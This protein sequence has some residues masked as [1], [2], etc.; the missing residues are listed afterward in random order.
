MKL[1]KDVTTAQRAN[2]RDSMLQSAC[3]VMLFRKSQRSS[4]LQKKLALYLLYNRCPKAVFGVLHRC[5]VS[6]SYEGALGALK[7]TSTRALEKLEKWKEEGCR[8]M[9]V[10]DNINFSVTASEDTI[11]AKT[12]KINATIG[13]LIRNRVD[14]PIEQTEENLAPQKKA[15][16]LHSGF[17]F[18]TTEELTLL[19]EVLTTLFGRVLADYYPALKALK[20]FVDQPITHAYS[21]YTKLAT[22]DQGTEI[23]FLDENKSTDIPGILDYFAVSPLSS[24]PPCVFFFSSFSDS[25]WFL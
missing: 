18:Q 17:L 14:N 3:A 19:T 9:A 8:L 2:E 20:G 10:A 25:F 5:G 24:P 4:V 22:E 23:L 13:Y 12:K 7:E 15:T 1:L 16:Q 11:D 21:D 6:L